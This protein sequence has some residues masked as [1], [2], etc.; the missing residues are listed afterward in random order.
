MAE[1][2]MASEDHQKYRPK[3]AEWK[4]RLGMI[5]SLASEKAKRTRE[6]RVMTRREGRDKGKRDSR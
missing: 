1:R 6:A 5:S 4:V 2:L 3:T